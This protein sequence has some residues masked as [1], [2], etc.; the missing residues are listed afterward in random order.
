MCG[1]VGGPYCDK[2]GL[3][4]LLFIVSLVLVLVL[5]L[6]SL[7]LLLVKDGLVQTDKGRGR[8]KDGGRMRGGGRD[9]WRMWSQHRTGSSV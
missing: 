4:S 5:G 9:G 1:G 3:V 6:C 2:E 8:R 7:V